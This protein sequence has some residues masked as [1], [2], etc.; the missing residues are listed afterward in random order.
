M[1]GNGDNSGEFLLP[2]LFT[3]TSSE[4]LGRRPLPRVLRERPIIFVLGPSGTGKSSVARRILSD[5]PGAVESSFRPAVVAAARNR[6]WAPELRTAPALLFDDVDCLHN[7]FGVQE[8]LG[9]LVRERALRGLRTV[10]C[11]GGGTDT[12]VTLL[13]DMVPLAL[14][15]SVLLRFPVGSGRRQHVKA[16]CLARDLPYA[17]ARS[18]V[19]MEPW[20][21]ALVESHLD[22]LVPPSA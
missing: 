14:R 1:A 8:M 16:R 19:L 5:I 4:L 17:G 6:V 12:S 11:Q 15:A 18:A 9:N 13:Y 10:L 3:R 7:R 21:Y 20:S 22:A 2:A